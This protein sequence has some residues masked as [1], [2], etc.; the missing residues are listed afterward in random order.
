MA[1][2]NF[3]SSS[4]LFFL[5]PHPPLSVKTFVHHKPG[6]FGGVWGTEYLCDAGK[7]EEDSLVQ[8]LITCRLKTLSKGNLTRSSRPL[9][10]GGACV[11]RY[12]LI[13]PVSLNRKCCNRD[14]A[15]RSD[16][17]VFPHP[18]GFSTMQ[19]SR[20]CGLS[21]GCAA[22]G[23]AT[24]ISAGF[25]ASIHGTEDETIVS[26]GVGNGVHVCCCCWA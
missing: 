13:Q 26:G 6:R 16:F 22:V 11:C 25:L 4:N 9:R 14:P 3:I 1:I 24:T 15:W 17:L 23:M 18:F 8:L 5:V 7:Y 2:T 21:L 10:C 12:D 19:C 20:R